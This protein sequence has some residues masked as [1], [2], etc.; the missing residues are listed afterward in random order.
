[1]KTFS[2]LLALVAILNLSACVGYHSDHHNQQQDTTSDDQKNISFDL[3]DN[4]SKILSDSS[5]TTEKRKIGLGK[6]KSSQ[7]ELHIP[8]GILSIK[9]GS[10]ELVEMAVRYKTRERELNVVQELMGDHL[11]AKISMPYLEGIKEIR[12]DG[13]LC[14]IRLNERIPMDLDINFGAG[15]GKMDLGEIQADQVRIGVGAGEFTINLAGSPVTSLKVDAGVGK[16]MVDISGKR[17]KDLDAV[18]NC[19]IG[20]LDLRLPVDVGV[21]VSISGL[22]GDVDSGDLVKKGEDWYNAAWEKEG[23]RIRIRINGGIGDIRLSM[24]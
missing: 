21:K 16:A 20:S 5:Y 11:K 2:R 17:K 13:S 22:L 9:G 18:F 15:K 6:V 12:D 19:G 7:L 1:M 3:Q 10:D 14:T 4:E 23:P 24:Q 8:A